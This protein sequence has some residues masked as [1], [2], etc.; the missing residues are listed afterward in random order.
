M[1]GDVSFLASSLFM[2]SCVHILVNAFT[3]TSNLFLAYRQFHSVPEIDS[4]PTL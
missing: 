1:P 2:G 4:A 3:I